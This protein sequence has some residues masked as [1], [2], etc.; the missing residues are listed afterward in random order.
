MKKVIYTALCVT[1]VLALP[2][3]W[4]SKEEQKPVEAVKQ[5]IP[6][7]AEASKPAEEAAPEAANLTETAEQKPAET[8]A[9]TIPAK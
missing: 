8:P 6:V 7:T 9:E 4:C 1:S 3:C 2:G 5:E